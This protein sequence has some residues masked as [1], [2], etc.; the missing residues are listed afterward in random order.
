M[1]RPSA[2]PQLAR[3]IMEKVPI[4]PQM[5]TGRVVAFSSS[6]LIVELSGSTTTITV[7]YLFGQSQIALGDTVYMVQQNGSWLALGCIAAPITPTTEV[8][9]PSFEEGDAGSAPPDWT[10]VAGAGAPTLTSINYGVPDFVDGGRVGALA[11]NG[12]GAVTADIYSAPIIAVENQFWGLAGSL[13]PSSAF[14]AASTC[15]VQ[16]F[17]SWFTSTSLAS[18]ISQESNS[19]WA[20]SRGQQWQLLRENGTSGRGC[21]APTGTR[22]LRLRLR[23]AWTS[24]AAADVVYLDRM[25]ARR[26]PW[27]PLL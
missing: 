18:V 26:M 3:A 1:N 8:I 27:V 17:A 23:I 13:M 15:T 4:A 20:V 21:R 9:N 19:T 11:S 12:A 7:A 22:Y 14:A 16:L 25:I 24:A 6:G 5:H 10:V 2:L